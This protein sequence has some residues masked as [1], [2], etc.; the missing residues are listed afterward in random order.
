VY[1][2]AGSSGQISGGT[3]N[4]PAM[5]ISLNNLG[6]LVLDI[7]SNRLDAKFIRENGTTND[8]FTILKLNYPPVASN[9]TFTV[10]A[11]ASTNLFFAASDLN[12][13]PVTYVTNSLPGR[14][15]ISDFDPALGTFRYT[16]AHGFSGTGSFNFSASDGLTNSSPASVTI[17]VLPPA[18]VNA[19][20]LPDYWEAAWNVN[21][22]NADEDG[23]GLSNL[24]EYLANTNPTNAAS[25]LRIFSINRDGS[26]Q[27]ML[28][29]ESIGGTRYRVSYSDGDA[30]G[31]FSGIF[32]DLVRPVTSEMDPAL[33]GTPSTMIFTDDFTLTGGVPGSGA[34]FYRVQVV[35]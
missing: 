17:T 32:T 15:L 14:G 8:S 26:G 19:N 18:D 29:W 30:G 7:A 20:G 33:V 9:L 34:R 31:G 10:A 23:D 27:I 1:V 28:A 12:R 21:D 11:D 2:V 25:A 22:P 6:S 3:L 4:H 13:N 35:K 5:Y 16:P 24:Q